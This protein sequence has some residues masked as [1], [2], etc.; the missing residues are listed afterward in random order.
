MIKRVYRL[1]LSAIALLLV[2]A[3]VKSQSV[4]KLQASD[5]KRL[6]LILAKAKSDTAKSM[7]LLNLGNYFE[8]Q[9]QPQEARDNSIFYFQQSYAKA[10]AAGVPGTH[11]KLESL[12]RLGE[13][14]TANGKEQDGNTYFLKAISEAQAARSQ[15]EEAVSWLRM[16]EVSHFENRI[17]C[18]Q[19]AI[20]LYQALKNREKELDVRLN[21]ASLYETYTKFDLCDSAAY[22]IIGD[23]QGTFPNKVAHA[24]YLLSE[25]NRYK[26]NL[27]ISLLNILKSIELHN[28]LAHDTQSASVFY[29][30]LGLVYQEMGDTQKSIYW[31]R[32][33]IAVRETWPGLAPIFI[34]RTVGFIVQQLIVEHRP[35]EALNEILSLEKG[36]AYKDKFDRALIAQ[37]KGECYDALKRSALAR[38]SYLTALKLYDFKAH[39]D[40]DEITQLLYYDL[41]RFYIGQHDYVEAARYLNRLM[42]GFSH[43]LSMNTELLKFKEDSAMRDNLS[44]ITHFKAY[45][46]YSDSIFSIAKTKQ[47]EELQIIYRTKEREKDFALLRKT[48][49]LQRERISSAEKEKKLTLAGVALLIILIALLFNGYRVKQK[50]NNEIRI[51]NDSLNQLIAEKD[52][53]LEEKQWLLKEIHHRVKNNLQIVMGLLQ[54]Q[55]SYVNN[56][57][58]LAAMQSTENRMRSIALIHQKLYQSQDINSIFMPEYINELITNLTETAETDN[59][60]QFEKKVE[61]IYLD[62]SQA[63]P[64]GLILNE[65]ITNAIKYAYPGREYGLIS[66]SLIKAAENITL[67]VA[68]QGSGLPPGFIPENATTLGLNLIKGLS[69]QLSGQLTIKNESGLTLSITF[70]PL[71]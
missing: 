46:A 13:T 51:K 32:K 37:F 34:I 44:A 55:S 64:L 9:R 16:A 8:R 57:E 18:Y 47:I 17:T 56:K 1:L 63:V 27:N 19:K 60:L 20:G 5:A 26:G 54:R 67:T 45:K 35:V 61:G 49:S 36:M 11:L 50:S 21:L 40:G 31:Y 59:R 52:N 53:L 48:E 70:S 39:T 29:G 71:T 25:S 42:P 3:A 33:T 66:V 10:V 62:V 2:S 4:E 22:A 7:A 43:T 58:A 6:L 41:A 12:R 65:A 38:Q 28:D 23:F 30:E 69:K 15:S 68:D 14:L 24:Y